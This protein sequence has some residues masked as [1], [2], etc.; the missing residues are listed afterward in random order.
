MLAA[1]PLDPVLALH[2]SDAMHAATSPA[3]MTH[4]ASTTLSQWSA[5]CFT[6]AIRSTSSSCS[7]DEPLAFAATMA[8]VMH[9][10][11][12]LYLLAQPQPLPQVILWGEH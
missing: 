9:V 6:H 4:K 1:C 12:S 5:A 11:L 7:L 10:L 8:V 2:V 3:A